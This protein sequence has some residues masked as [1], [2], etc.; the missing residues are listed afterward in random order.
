MTSSQA[1]VFVWCV[2]RSWVLSLHL[3]QCFGI[4]EPLVKM[5]AFLFHDGPC[6]VKTKHFPLSRFVNS[7]NMLKPQ[8]KCFYKWLHTP[9]HSLSAG[10][11][12]NTRF[13][14]DLKMNTKGKW[15]QGK[16]FHHDRRRSPW[17]KLSDPC[18]SNTGE[19]AT[20]LHWHYFYI[21]QW[22]C[23]HHGG[24]FFNFFN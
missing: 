6:R 9:Y 7:W 8:V 20:R 3:M 22:N 14:A 5:S 24:F 17:K 15:S 19:Y 12:G 10:W 2:C 11:R 23:Q 1:Q 16:E 4:G 21:D 13:C 18:S